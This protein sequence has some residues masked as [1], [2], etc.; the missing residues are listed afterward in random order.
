VPVNVIAVA[1]PAQIEVV[2]EIVTVGSA[3]IITVNGI[4][5]PIQPAAVTALT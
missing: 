2:P 4:L 3:L 1:F 5:G